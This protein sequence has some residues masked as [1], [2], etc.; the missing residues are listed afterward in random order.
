MRKKIL[1]VDDDALNRDILTEYL[2]EGGYEVVE[3][4]DGDTALKL[5]NEVE[6]IDAIVLDRMM[7][8]LNGMEVL[9]AVKRDKRFAHIP[10][11]M[12]SAASARDQILQGIKAGVYYYLT[13][14]YEDQMLLAIVRAALQDASSKA[15][16]RREVAQ[17]RRVIGLMEQSRFRFRTMEEARNLAF[18]I[19]NGFPEPES[20]VYGLN[21][22]LANAVEHGNLGIAYGEKTQLVLEGRLQKEIEKRLD[23]AENR[24]KWAFLYFEADDRSVRVRIKDQGAGFDWRPY[25]EISPERATHPHGRGIATSKLMSFSSLEYL[26]CGNEVLCAVTLP[27]RCG[28]DAYVLEEA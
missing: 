8:R 11:I 3:A 19:A 15:K 7:P 22:L 9:K 25:L 20:A 17:H 5:L 24:D 27:S 4:D 18:L 16:L 2:S 10:V 26:G 14:P 13:K 6:N 23:L 1:S 28:R 12:Q 21:E